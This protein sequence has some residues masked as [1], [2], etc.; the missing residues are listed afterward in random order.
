MAALAGITL[1]RRGTLR[2]ARFTNAGPNGARIQLSGGFEVVRHRGSLLMRPVPRPDG[3]E[4]APLRG[5]TQFGAWRFNVLSERAAA[6]EDSDVWSAELPSDALLAVRHW[7]NGDRMRW[8]GDARTGMR[9]VARF[10]ADARIEAGER[11]DWPVVTAGDEIVWIPG[12]RRA[13]AVP[14]RS[15]RPAVRYV[16]ERSHR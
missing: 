10:L 15:G 1:D 2:L 16:C 13:D 6:T 4:S 5:E 9:R 7:K 3:R 8:S 14:A 12:V 11:R